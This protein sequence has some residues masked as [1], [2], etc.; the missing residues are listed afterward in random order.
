M[1]NVPQQTIQTL[2]RT[3]GPVESE[4]RSNITNSKMLQTYRG[5]DNMK[6][7]II[8]QSVLRTIG[9]NAS[10]SIMGDQKDMK[11]SPSKDLRDAG[12]LADEG[13]SP[14]RKSIIF[15]ST[16]VIENRYPLNITGQLMPT[17][18]SPYESSIMQ[19]ASPLNRIESFRALLH[20]ESAANELR[21]ISNQDNFRNLIN[22]E[23]TRKEYTILSTS[24]S[25]NTINISNVQN[26]HILMRKED[27][28][29][30]TVT[31][32]FLEENLKASHKSMANPSPARVKKIQ[33]D[34][35]H[36][37]E[38]LARKIEEIRAMESDKIPYLPQT[39]EQSSQGSIPYG[40][41]KNM[42]RL[43]E[44]RY[45]AENIDNTLFMTFL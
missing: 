16:G 6:L 13:T 29:L 37:K 31:N 25:K 19:K 3:G 10:T 44:G 35:K 17:Q 5:S 26:Q 27:D 39:A 42:Q 41:I 12:S 30:H 14:K 43:Q 23:V 1:S 45:S 21:I 24:P 7:K 4:S 34:V 2:R 28:M 38:Q 11:S 15:D 22:P 32:E 36:F 20:Q 33:M 40:T 8:D 9:A 18:L